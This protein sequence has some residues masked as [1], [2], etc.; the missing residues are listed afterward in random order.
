MNV[1]NQVLFF[2]YE[3]YFTTVGQPNTGGLSTD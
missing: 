2:F 1:S 3:L